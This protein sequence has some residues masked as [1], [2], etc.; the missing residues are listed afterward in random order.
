MILDTIENFRYRSRSFSFFL[1]ALGVLVLHSAQ[2]HGLGLSFFLH[3]VVDDRQ[4]GQPYDRR[5]LRAAN[6]CQGAEGVSALHYPGQ[7][8]ALILEEEE[9]LPRYSIRSGPACHTAAVIDT[10]ASVV[11]SNEK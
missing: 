3:H 2:R 7:I 6:D 5:R 8:S 1:F 10:H 11:I 9:A 4:C